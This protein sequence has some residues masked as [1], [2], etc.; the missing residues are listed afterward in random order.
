M[1]DVFARKALRSKAIQADASEIEFANFSKWNV[2][3][4][5]LNSFLFL[6][7]KLV[8]YYKTYLNIHKNQS[9]FYM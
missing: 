2:N 7:Y 8:I 4:H 3:F 6:L 9:K 5:F 1:V